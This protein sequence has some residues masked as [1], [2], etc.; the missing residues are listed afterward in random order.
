MAS[1]EQLTAVQGVL[2]RLGIR[3]ENS[4]ACWGEW[5]E[6]PAG[7]ELVSISPVD[8]TELARVRQAAE[9]DYDEVVWNAAQTFERWRML[10]APQRGQIV[11][12]IGDELRRAKEDLGTLVTLEMGKILAEGLG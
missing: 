11:R 12:E 3:A 10:P 9:E 1:T 5:I 8:G 7:T 4:G 2:D 6:R